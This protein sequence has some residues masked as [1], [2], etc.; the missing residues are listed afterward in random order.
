MDGSNLDLFK[1]FLFEAPGD[2]PPPDLGEEP[3]SQDLNNGAPPEL[4]DD[5]GDGDMDSPPELGGDDMMMGGD[6]GAPP[7]LGDDT[8]FGDDEGSGAEQ[9]PNQNME[10]DEKISAIM[11]ANLYQRFLSLLGDVT[12]QISAIKDNSDII[13]SLAPD[14]SKTVSSLKKLEENINL[15]LNNYFATENY[16]KNLLF[17]NKCLNLL[18]LLNDAFDKNIQ[19]GIRTSE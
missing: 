12:N 1:Q 4:N 18:K 11:N 14:S 2:D 17:F 16:S 8:G 6:D 10:V 15:Y 13:Y 3:Q 9:D 5:S 7:E 19:K